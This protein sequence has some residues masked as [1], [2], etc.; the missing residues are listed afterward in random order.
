MLS[1][2]GSLKVFLAVE[3]CDM[4]KGFNGLPSLVSE[5]LQENPQAG[6]LFVFT[7]KRHNRLKILFWDRTGLWV[8]TKRLEE[9]TFSW[10]KSSEGTSAKLSL[11]PEALSLLTDGVDLRDAKFRPWYQ[12]D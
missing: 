4:R 7:N 1:F 3:P 11:S 8:C 5:R 2:A 12:R 6:S 10:P 9:G